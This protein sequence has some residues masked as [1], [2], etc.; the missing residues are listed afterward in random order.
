MSRYEDDLPIWDF[1]AVTWGVV[2]IVAIVAWVIY[3]IVV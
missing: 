2:A 1:W 3:G